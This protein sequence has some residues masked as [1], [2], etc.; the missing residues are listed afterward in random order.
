MKWVI[1]KREHRES[2]YLPGQ[3]LFTK[4]MAPPLLDDFMIY[5]TVFHCSTQKAFI[6]LQMEKSSDAA[7]VRP[8]PVALPSD[9]KGALHL[10]RRFDYGRT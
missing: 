3:N 7:D 1:S 9:R 4:T 5:G 6:P 2:Y 8:L 10:T